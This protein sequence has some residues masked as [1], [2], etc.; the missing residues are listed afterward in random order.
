MAVTT[1]RNEQLRSDFITVDGSRAANASDNSY[2][3]NGGVG[4]NTVP[5]ILPFDAVLVAMSMSTNGNYT[6]TLE[7]E[8]DEVLKTGATLTCT[9][10]DSA[11]ADDYAVEFSAGDKIMFRIDST[12]TISKPKGSAVFKRRYI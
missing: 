7:I 3:D 6:W 5:V 9:A 8:V 2:L 12:G 1:I 11:S 10:A 4:M